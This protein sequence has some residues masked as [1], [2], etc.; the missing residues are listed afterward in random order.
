LLA[1]RFI[2]EIPKTYDPRE[3]EA[4]HY[5]RWEAQGYFAPEVNRDPEAPVY[6]IVIP[7]PNVTGSLHMGHALQH[8]IMDVLTRYHRMCG[9]RTLWLP[10]SDHAGISTQLMVERELR[11]EGLTR[12][13]L[14]REQF[15]E[16][17]WRWKEQYG[18]E[19]TRQM[20]REGASV[21][22]S[23]EQ[24][25]MDEHLSRAVREFFVRCYDEGLIYHGEGLI[26][27]C[28]KDQTALSDLEVDKEETKGAL[29]YLQYPVKGSERRVTVAT[30]RPE[31]M[32]GDTAVAVNPEDERYRDLLGATITLP[33]VGREIPVVADEFVDP[34]FGT[35]AVKV[36]PAHD[37][38][39]YEMGRRHN[40]PQVRV[41]DQHARMTAEAGAEFAGLDRYEARGLVVKRFEELGLLEK[42]SDYE[43]SITKC[44]RCRTVIEPLISTQWFLKQAELGRA[45]LALVRER[46]EPRFVPRVPYEKVYADWLENLHDWT[47]S[48]QLWWG[49][50]VPAWYD[51]AGRV[52]VAR[53]EAE[54]RQQA[55]T[56][57]LTQDP[58]VLDTWFSSALWPLSTLGWPDDTADL[59]TFYP[60]NVLV[61]ARDIIFLWVSRMM[62]TG[63]KFTGQKAFAD[64][65]I[66]GTI[67]DKHGQRMS[68]MKGNGVDPLEMFDRYGVDATRLVLAQIESTDTRW[69]DKQI[70][71]YRNFA[72]KIWNAARFCLLNAEGASV[73]TGFEG[74]PSGWALHDRWIVSRLNRTAQTVSDA[75][76]NYRFHEAVQTIYHFF[77]DDFCDWYIELTKADVTATADSPA[78]ASARGR[79]LTVLEQ[80]LRLLHPFMPFITEELWQRLPGVGARQLH[81]AYRHAEPTV[82]LAEYPRADAALID[83]RAEAEMQ[84]LI[85]LISRVRNIRAEM[86]I[87]PGETVPVLVG[88]PDDSLR[89]V[90]AAG[91]QQIARLV[92]ASEVRVEPSVDGPRAAARAVLAGGAEVA[93]PL[94]GLIDFAVER[95]RLR[96]EQD[97][98]RKEAE[99]L[100]AQL[101]NENFVARAPA[102]KVAELRQRLADIAQRTGAL[103]QTL[104]A[105]A[106]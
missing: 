38:N 10:G 70:E 39:D 34:A 106:E 44:G 26:S 73:G 77:W 63:V 36:T 102:E 91:A 103:A 105:L 58:D 18:G 60:T 14:G 12:H 5:A 45:P 30:T 104:E 72:N 101:A 46:R 24:F 48:R 74:A 56:D 90:F 84:A 59:R 51:E 95:E 67:F 66:T 6:S 41:I 100:E 9:Y 79:V 1:A 82:M 75:I 22:W 13:D 97:K 29:Y 50:R 25:T 28:P 89:A 86:N 8:T 19:I 94:E 37:P 88:V 52:Y 35:G 85:E 99:K 16:R 71:S 2:M 78:R 69:N 43:F 15:I 76:E 4:R 80:A 53:T 42:V 17:V 40:L 49:H 87:K 83:V 81:P 68:K 61:T 64:V 55:G 27:W 96:K 11:K 23:R 33:L 92:R 93:V 57:E 20:R 31:T 32:L 62:M 7:P 21:D 65:F 54:A 98:L 3:A 47:L